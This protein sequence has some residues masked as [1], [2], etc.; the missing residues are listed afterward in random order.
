VKKT[1]KIS[2]NFSSENVLDFFS[3]LRFLNY[4]EDSDKLLNI[5]LCSHEKEIDDGD[6]KTWFTH[7][8]PPISVANETSVLK[9][10][11]DLVITQL[12]KYP[13]DLEYDAKIMEECK[14]GNSSLNKNQK[15]CLIL[16]LGEKKVKI[17]IIYIHNFKDIK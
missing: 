17:L 10:I 5:L 8:I 6:T 12:A 16:R 14:K 9:N 7:K 3:F 2:E 4:D 13:T 11:K 15:N 1:F